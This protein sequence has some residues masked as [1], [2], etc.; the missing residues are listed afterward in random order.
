MAKI[1][2][3]DEDVKALYTLMHYAEK[4]AG[5]DAHNSVSRILSKLP[6]PEPKEDKD[7][8]VQ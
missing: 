5:L 3:D 8:K 7:A 6:I 2:F 1:D 4:Y